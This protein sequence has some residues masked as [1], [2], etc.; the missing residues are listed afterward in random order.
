MHT[1]N[2]VTQ[3]NKVLLRVCAWCEPGQKYF[4]KLFD[5]THGICDNHLSLMMDELTVK[6]NLSNERQ[7]N[8]NRK[9]S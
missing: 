8:D 2:N 3:C 9:K 6:R 7:K 4:T 1:K 5:I